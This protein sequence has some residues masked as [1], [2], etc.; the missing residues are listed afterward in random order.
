[1]SGALIPGLVA[2]G[3]GTMTLAAILAR[4]HREESR[5]RASRV[6][7]ALRFPAGVEPAQAVAALDSLS[8]HAY[9]NE[10]IFELTARSMEIR[11]AVWVPASVRDSV[12]ASLTGTLPGLRLRETEELPTGAVTLAARL[13]VPTPIL[14]ATDRPI[15]GSH[16]L[17]A[18]LLVANDEQVVVRFALRGGAARRW[19]AREDAGP[20]EQETER[21]WRR[22]IAGAGF[23]VAGLVLVRAGTVG[24]ARKLLRHVEAQVATRR[25]QRRAIRFTY[26]RGNRSLASMPR[27]TR[28][29][30]WLTAAEL[31]PLL[32]WPL[33]ATAPHGVEV[34]AAR[35]LPAPEHLARTGRELFIGRDGRGETRPIALDVPASR[36]HLLVAGPSGTGKS[37]LLAR[38]V[39]SDLE[40]G[41]GG[42][43]LDP[44][45]DLV[46][47]VLDRVP[48]AHASRVVVL[49]AADRSR[50]IPGVALLS[51]I[52]D[53]DLR[54][55][56]LTGALRSIFSDVWSVRSDYYV[57]LA[58][59]TLAEV[60]EAKLSDVGRLFFEPAF[61]ARA[62]A[63]LSDPFLH[64]AWAQYE[65]LSSGAKVEAVAA[66]MA[67]VMALLNM[68]R[69]RAVLSSPVPRLDVAQLMRE[70][71]LLLVSLA[72][73]QLGEGPANFIAA[74]LVYVAW[75]AIEARTALRPEE[76][77]PITLYVDELS[78]LTTAVP[79]SFELL[80]ERARGLGAAL[81]ISVQSLARVPEPTRASLLAN[82]ATL[83]SFRTSADDGARLAR[84][85]PGLTPA[86]LVGL[87]R[88]EVA[89][90]VAHGTGGAVSIVTG[91]TLPL[92]EPTGLADEIRDQSAATYGAPPED[93]PAPPQPADND[94]PVGRKRRQ[95]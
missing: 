9:P 27:T 51:A 66:P 36:H 89:A 92:P 85:L 64:T 42:L 65:R 90:R 74:A 16:A 81:A 68:P 14:L 24:H 6:R 23:D 83:I 11:H 50:P 52:G 60:P 67:R 25:T 76:R 78:T 29:S 70:R 1:V 10:L 72:P 71:K 56:V 48:P 93:Q 39:L 31:C 59:R 4:E 86:D 41:H 5:M 3:G 46:Q 15:E 8:G 43:L 20:E 62:T 61:R 55:E 7:L 13:F 17:L 21:S 30:G 38:A 35:E 47:A 57:R 77:T 44:K 26:E 28:S 12:V 19:Q 32:A 88:F 45:S 73:G 18:G 49:D 75:A 54:A 37:V 40:S 82:V 80:A 2:A 34:G 91:E 94:A 84:E 33:G 95:P 22:K 58:V 87:G 63:R 53:A 79:F 69:V